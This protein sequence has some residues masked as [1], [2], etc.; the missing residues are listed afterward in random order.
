MT[1]WIIDNL[2]RKVI[3]SMKSTLRWSLLAISLVHLPP[4]V[5]SDVEVGSTF[6]DFNLEDPH[7]K[8]YSQPYLQDKITLVV[9]QSKTTLQEAIRCKTELKKTIRDNPLVQM[10]SIMDLRKRPALIPKGVLKSK[11]SAQDQTSKDIP[12][13]LDWDGA[14]TKALGGVDNKCK[15][16]VIDPALKVVYHQEYHKPPIDVEIKSLITRLSGE[17]K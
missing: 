7:G 13:L 11:I 4:L 14:V 17:Q 15:I 12:F 1:T 8:K 10:I 6:V 2:L 9:L 3:E 16:L 5:V